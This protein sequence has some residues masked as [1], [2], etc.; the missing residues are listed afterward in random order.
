[1][2]DEYCWNIT[3]ESDGSK[4][5][6]SQS[7]T[8]IVMFNKETWAG[9]TLEWDMKV[10]AGT[11][12]YNV[13]SG[14]V[15]GADSNAVTNSTG[16]Y[17]V[18]GRDPWNEFVAYSK[19]END[20]AWED[21]NKTA[22]VYTDVNATYHYKLIWDAAGKLIHYFV[23]GAYTASA[24]LKRDAGGVHIGL[25][26]DMAGVEFSHIVYSNSSADAP[27]EYAYT[28]FQSSYW[29]VTGEG[30]SRVYSA[31]T[32]GGILTFL[33]PTDYTTFAFDLKVTGTTNTYN[34]SSGLLLGAKTAY[35]GI[36]FG[37]FAVVGRD[38]WGGFNTYS[39]NDGAFAWNDSNKAAGAMPDLNTV[40]HLKVVLD[41]TANTV[42]Y[43][44]DGVAKGVQTTSVDVSGHYWGLVSDQACE[45]SN[46][47]L[48]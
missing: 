4:K 45:F 40:Y 43:F 22:A 18:A 19:N 29:T 28:A 25:Y 8:Q 7:T 32:G 30:T 12:T 23:N 34:C 15:F 33:T 26:A 31:L 13:V 16:K 24:T 27:S 36:N 44:L 46:I 21:N 3:T 39:K 10:G 47:V 37:T 11:P 14:V 35:A 17:Y 48:S 20:F 1:V 38:D 9:G 41:R 42:S 6:V 2:G 5:F